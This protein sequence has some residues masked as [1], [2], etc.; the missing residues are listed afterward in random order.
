MRF[1]RKLLVPFSRTFSR[2]NA[3]RTLTSQES[4]AK[5][6]TVDKNKGKEY[7]LNIIEST[8]DYASE[9][10]DAYCFRKNDIGKSNR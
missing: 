8:M 7:I 4:H 5:C 1:L 2:N 6:T 10:F 9:I 3:R